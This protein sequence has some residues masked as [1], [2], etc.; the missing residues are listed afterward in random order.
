MELTQSDLMQEKVEAYLKSPSDEALKEII[1]ASEGLIYHFARFYGG[2]FCLDDL[3][4]AGCEGIIKA[5][6]TY[7]QDR[8]IRFVTHASHGI[9]GEIR[10]YVRKERRYYYP[11]YLDNYLEKAHE[12][13]EDELDHH[14]A[15]LSDEQLADKLNLSAQSLSP[16]MAAGLVHLNHLDLSQIKAKSYEHFSLPI[17]DKLFITQLLYK[18]TEIQKDVIEM[19]FY[20][21]MTQEEVAKELGITQKQVSRIKEKSLLKMKEIIRNK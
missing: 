10:H 21:D 19:V 20:R 17:E 9:M 4:Q 14:D 6:K 8:G 18:L 16:I 11:A 1:V 12:Y 13:M 3:F 15:M 7:D 5:L 2:G